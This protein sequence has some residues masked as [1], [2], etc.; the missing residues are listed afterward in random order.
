MNERQHQSEM[1][2]S[3][4]EFDWEPPWHEVV[5]APSRSPP[6]R[7]ALPLAGRTV[8]MRSCAANQPA[9][10]APSS[11]LPTG[12]TETYTALSPSAQRFSPTRFI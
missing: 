1:T 8:A 3:L 10:A 9:L 7:A 12:A 4:F 5:R 2:A 11:S 6:V